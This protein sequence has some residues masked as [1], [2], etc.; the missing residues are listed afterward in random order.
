MFGPL[1]LNIFICDTFYFIENCY[2]CN[3][4]HGNRFYGNMNVVKEK[5]YKDF[6]VLDA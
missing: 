3:Y 2:L 1:L 6:K 5:L 4:A